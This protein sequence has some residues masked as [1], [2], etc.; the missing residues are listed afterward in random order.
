MQNFYHNNK[1]TINEI[2][3]TFHVGTCQAVIQYFIKQQKI[4]LKLLPYEYNMQDM[5]RFEVLGQDML[6]TKYGWVYHFNAIP[7]NPMTRD[8]KYWIK[9]TYEEVYG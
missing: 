5:T 3:N 8:A 1:Q 7:P 4:D 9:R 2:Q 6:H